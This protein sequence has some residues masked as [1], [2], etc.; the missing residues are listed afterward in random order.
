MLAAV[1]GAVV[2]DPGFDALA[3][4]GHAEAGELAVSDDDLAFG[5]RLDLIHHGLAQLGLALGD[6]F[7]PDLSPCCRQM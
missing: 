2:D 4:D 3:G 6:L 1:A 7:H 5:R